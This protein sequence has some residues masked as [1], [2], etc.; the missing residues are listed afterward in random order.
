MAENGPQNG[1]KNGSK[2]AQKW[3]KNGSKMGHFWTPFLTP[4]FRYWP[5]LAKSNGHIRGFG[6]L[7]A[8]TPQKGVKK[9]SKNDP[10]WGPRTPFWPLF[11][12][13]MAQKRGPLLRPLSERSNYSPRGFR[14]K[15][16]KKRGQFLTKSGQKWLKKWSKNGSKISQ[17]SCGE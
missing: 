17:K 10:F 7:L 15:G 4:I 1:S 14:P 9:W 16:V 11:G 5:V 3:V 2:M 13:K 8:K 6:P 12:S